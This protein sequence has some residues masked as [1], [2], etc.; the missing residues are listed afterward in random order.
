MSLFKHT[1]CR[2]YLHYSEITPCIL[3]FLIP[4]LLKLC[5][6]ALPIW[7][8]QVF[9]CSSACQLMK[10]K[11]LCYSRDNRLLLPK[12]NRYKTLEWN[13]SQDIVRQPRLYVKFGED[14]FIALQFN[15]LPNVLAKNVLSFSDISWPR[16]CLYIG[17]RKSSSRLAD[18]P[19]IPDDME[20]NRTGRTMSHPSPQLDQGR[21]IQCGAVISR[22]ISPKIPTIDT[23]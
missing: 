4:N 16:H 9:K 6:W 10:K 13:Y 15:H 3:N 21:K 18:N 23:P 20:L 11:S 5:L 7:V 14:V 8:R 17:C 12:I 2:R 1:Y 22:P 19:L